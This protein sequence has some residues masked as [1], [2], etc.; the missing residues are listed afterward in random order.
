MNKE[1]FLRFD[2]VYKS[3]DGKNTVI[4]NLN[5]DIYQG[6][7]LTMLGPSGSGKTTCLMLLAGFQ[8]VTKGQ[9]YLKNQ[10]ITSTPPHKRN[11]GM[12]FQNYALFPHMSVEQNLAFPLC[13]RKV[14]KKERTKRIADALEMVKM[15]EFIKRFPGQLSGGQKQRVALARAL[16]FDAQLILMDEPLGALDKQLR[17]HMQYEIMKIHQNLGVTIV[18][19]THDQ[20]EALTMSNRIAV[21]NNGKIQQLSKPKELYEAPQNSFVAQFIGENNQISGKIIRIEKDYCLVQIED[22]NIWCKK[23][24]QKLKTGDWASLSLRPEH[25]S[26]VNKELG[27]EQINYLDAKI[28]QTI[29]QGESTRI[30]V[31]CKSFNLSI[32]TSNKNTLI[33]NHQ[34]T[35][36]AFSYDNILALDFVQKND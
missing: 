11:I 26:L 25:I 34:S 21:F 4:K 36:V 2:S 24:Y 3:Y 23:A 22:I 35:K 17:E 32:K 8:T 14:P 10:L 33:N 16:I 12:V 31:A 1:N 18:Y 7:F 19:V 5:L 6:E 30:I 27:G 28:E 13:A 9:I 29:Y 15:G 20:S